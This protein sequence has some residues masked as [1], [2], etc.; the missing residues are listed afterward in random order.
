MMLLLLHPLMP[1]AVMGA[2]CARQKGRYQR[3]RAAVADCS[4]ADLASAAYGCNS[5]SQ[6]AS[7]AGSSPFVLGGDTEQTSDRS[8]SVIAGSFHGM[9]TNLQQ[10][11][12]DR[13]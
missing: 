8:S 10:V 2:Q 9:G 7:T 11:F 4:I 12:Y 1:H 3:G 5:Q 13:G 6:G